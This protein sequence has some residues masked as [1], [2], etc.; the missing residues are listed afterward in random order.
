MAD[1]REP[2]HK[3]HELP[4]WRPGKGFWTRLPRERLTGDEWRQL[5][6]LEDRLRGT[7]GNAFRAS[8]LGINDGLVTNLSLTMGVVGASM[9]ARAVFL[10][11]LASLF[12]GAL[13][14]ALG[15][16]LSVQNSRELHERQLEIEALQ[17]EQFPEDERRELVDI[18]HGKGLSRADA[19]ALA[20]RMMADRSAVLDTMAR[21]EWG[22]DPEELGGS[23][24][25]AA[26]MSFATF[27]VGAAL[28]ILPFLWLSVE[29]AA[30]ASLAVGTVGLLVSG[31]ATSR[32]TGRNPFVSGL[33]QVLVGLAAAG[34][35]YGI[36]RLFQQHALP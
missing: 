1:V 19:E 4:H 17:I 3:A 32:L 24:W 34:I 21:E 31:A 11:G 23:A 18:Y 16:W 35:T 28:P 25:Q 26:G 29:L 14:M 6:E 13:S 12:A 36:V 10:A 30:I 8:V 7:S 9:T 15:E 5:A 20:T 2:R 33:R 22:I 27:A